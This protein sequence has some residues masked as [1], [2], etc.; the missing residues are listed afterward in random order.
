MAGFI[1]ADGSFQVRTSL[2]SKYTRVS[3]SLELTQAITTKRGEDV[4]PI[5]ELIAKLLEVQVNF[6]RSGRQHP[7]YRIRT[8]TV[9][10]NIII[11]NYLKKFSLFSSKL[12]DF[13]D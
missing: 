9:K 12:L 8:S 6:I 4:L 11:L 7:Q 10:S 5:M 1:D 2:N 3:C 13:K